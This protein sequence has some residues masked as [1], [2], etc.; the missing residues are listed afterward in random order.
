MPAPARCPRC[1]RSLEDA[2]VEGLCLKCL[3]AFGLEAPPE[4]P[5][6]LPGTRIGDYEVVG[7]I[8]RGGM[9][10]VFKA[11]KAG[12]DRLVALKRVVGGELADPEEQQR[13][14]SEAQKAAL[15]DHPNI[16]PIYDVGEH[17]GCPFFTMKLLDGGSLAE[18][19]GRYRAQ[20]REAC[21]L[22][23]VLAHAVHHGHQRQ[24]LHRD[25]KPANVLFDAQGTPFIA[26]FGVARLMEPGADGTRSGAVVG[27]L[28]YMAPEQARGEAKRVTT[29]A[30]VHGLGAMLYELVTGHRPYQAD[31]VAATLRLTTDAEPPAPR[32]L[33]PALDETL[34]A[35]CLRC[36]EKDPARRYA[37]AEALAVE[38]ERYLRGDET[39]AR[40]LGRAARVRRWARRHPVAT[41]AG[42]ALAVLVAAALWAALKQ[43]QKSRAD[44]LAANAYA[45]RMAAGTVMSRLVQYREQ[46]RFRENGEGVQ[47]P[48]RDPS[49]I[50]ALEAGDH[51]ALAD[52]PLP[53]GVSMPRRLSPFDFWALLDAG[54]MLRARWPALP[55]GTLGR[56]LSW[57]DEFRVARKV[58]YAG[59]RTVHVSRVFLDVTDGRAKLSFS[60]PMFGTHGTMVGVL[61][62]AIP[63]TSAPVPLGLGV[64]DDP[65]RIA[66]LLGPLHPAGPDDAQSRYAVL[67]HPGASGELV[68]FEAKRLAGLER[69]GSHLASETD[70]QLRLAGPER[71]VFDDH[72]A[73]PVPGFEGRWLAGLAPVGDTGY[74]IVVQTR[75]GAVIAPLLHALQR[76]AL[77]L[78]AV[79][80]LALLV[81]RRLRA[82]A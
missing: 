24:V 62:A 11:K 30:D 40:P 29:A 73:D 10:V 49:L 22:I 33:E 27:T 16:V 14:R 34:E 15:L 65:D 43:E 75:Y 12:L 13:I 59:K 45:A 20:P 44:V 37:S 2:T 31:T 46:F 39:E 47:W 77:P 35:I 81:R 82:A 52:S 66:A 8:A 79:L 57:R 17:D 7:R 36:L 76:I 70:D 58:A 74:V 32:A 18:Q 71:T 72:Y 60:T 26:D 28:G 5:E 69:L 78:V 53:V 55:E 23:A 41:L 9:G 4:A 48:A 38:L 3:L 21:A 6:L 42:A 1:G 61:G 68:A 19:L 67:V 56:D 54:G 80:L 51:A 63:A 50:L 64:G 25:L